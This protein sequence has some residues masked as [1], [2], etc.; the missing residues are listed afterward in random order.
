MV[1]LL[2]RIRRPCQANVRERR[3]PHTRTTCNAGSNGQVHA[4]CRDPVGRGPQRRPDRRVD[5][6]SHGH[7]RCWEEEIGPN[8]DCRA[9]NE[10]PES[11]S[12]FW[13]K[14]H[15]RPNPDRWTC[16]TDDSCC[17]SRLE[18]TGIP[19]PQSRIL[20]VV[21][22]WESQPAIRAT[23]L[24]FARMFHSAPDL[25]RLPIMPHVGDTPRSQ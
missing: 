23:K 1:F 17:E 5:E 19:L 7:A 12:G 24:R 4:G 22:T 20:P 3:C 13:L 11:A 16:E 21:V 2:R 18:R 15:D 6:T 9:F 10:H 8:I 14:D 25:L